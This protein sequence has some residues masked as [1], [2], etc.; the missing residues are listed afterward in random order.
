L[1]NNITKQAS[2]KALATRQCDALVAGLSGESFNPTLNKKL[3]RNKL[4]IMMLIDTG[5]RVNELI[6]L[7]VRNLIFE[8]KAVESLE[9]PD[10]IAKGNRGRLIPLTERLQKE[11][12]SY[13]NL[14]FCSNIP[15]PEYYIFAHWVG[16]PH[17]TA[18]QVQRVC[19][20]A[21]LAFLGISVNPHMLRHTFGTRLMRIAP[22]E[23][24]RRL[25]GHSCLSSTQIYMHP[26]TDDLKKA[27]D[28]L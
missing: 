17:I 20:I 22:I 19:S 18:R 2:P 8:G 6:Q 10:E 27:I 16:A 23:V 4:M 26:D 9:L 24:V 13:A 11:I 1:E 12:F 5:L 25:M 21:G 28:S 15:N 3:K 14:F 7:R